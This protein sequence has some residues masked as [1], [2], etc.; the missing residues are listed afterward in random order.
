MEIPI[1]P[2]L[3][4]VL[5]QNEEPPGTVGDHTHFLKKKKTSRICLGGALRAMR[6]GKGKEGEGQGW[7]CEAEFSL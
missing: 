5:G 2:D 6:K 4:L 1:P 7:L 3:S